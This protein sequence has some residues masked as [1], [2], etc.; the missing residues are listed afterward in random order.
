MKSP[1]L[2]H[3]SGDGIR[4]PFTVGCW[5]S[6]G[7]EG[8]IGAAAGPHAVTRGWASCPGAPAAACIGH[9]AKSLCG[10]AHFCGSRTLLLLSRE[11]V[12]FLLEAGDARA[13]SSL[14]QGSW[15]AD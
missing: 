4:G 9:T 5:S 2:P 11:A 8:A 1:V 12:K 10:S 14:Q 7:Q 6:A 3:E 15:G 13:G